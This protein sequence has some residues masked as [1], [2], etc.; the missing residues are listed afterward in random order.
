[1]A[2][3][4]SLRV[5]QILISRGEKGQGVVMGRLL[6]SQAVMIHSFAAMY[7]SGVAVKAERKPEVRLLWSL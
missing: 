2:G 3:D 5:N 7:L 6:F 4:N 1:M